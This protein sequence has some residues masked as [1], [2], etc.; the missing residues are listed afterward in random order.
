MDEELINR[1][2]K[3]QKDEEKKQEGQN[4]NYRFFLWDLN[5]SLVS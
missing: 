3:Y 1:Y 2:V 4:K 5:Y